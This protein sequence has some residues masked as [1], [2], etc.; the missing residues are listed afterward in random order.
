MATNLI[1]PLNG[2]QGLRAIVKNGASTK[3]SGQ[4][5]VVGN[6]H[7]LLM[8]D[9]AANET[10]IPA[11]IGDYEIRYAKLTTD[12]VVPG[13][14]LYFDAGNDRFTKVATNNKK[15]GLANE[16]SISSQATIKILFGII[17]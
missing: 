11:V 6:F 15:A 12:D 13:D 14:I 17:R 10:G 3:T 7:A 4:I 8:K 5:I 16:T 9:A 2:A 1:R